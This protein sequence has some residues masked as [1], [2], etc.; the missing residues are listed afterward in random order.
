MKDTM[1][2]KVKVSL[3]LLAVIIFL[4]L[5]LYS[6]KSRE[7]M[8]WLFARTSYYF[9][10]AL[11]LMWL[12]QLGRY[13]SGVDFSPKDFVK[14][15]WPGF[16]LALGVTSIVFATIPVQFK[17]LGDETNLLS[18]SQDM[19]YHKSA[20]IISM[21]TFYNG[22]L[23]VIDVSIPNRPL[24]FPFAINI[25]HS[26]LGYRP[27]NV[28]ILNF[29]LMFIFLAGVYVAIKKAIDTPTAVAGI[30]LILAYPIITI[31]ATSGGYDLFSTLLFAV[32]LTVF[33]RFLKSPDEKSLAFLWVSLLIFSNIRYESCIFFPIIIAA[34]LS[35]I[36]FSYFKETAYIY[37][38][39]PLLSLPFIWQRFLSLG[40]YEN[41]SNIPLF[42]VQSFIKHGKIFLQNYLNLNLDLPYSGFLNLAA[43][44]IIGY[45]F[46][47]IV[48]QK[49]KLTPS[50][51]NLTITLLLCVTVIMVIVLSHHFG[52]YD[53]PTQARLFMY[54]SVFCALAP[55][56]L[57][58]V[59]P[60]W[61]SGK[62]LMVASFA[63][64]LFY[65][66]V[67]GNHAFINN[68]VITRIH[69]YA[70]K[71]LKNLNDPDVL[72]ISAYAGQY[73]ALNY[74]AVTFNYANQHSQS[75]LT[76]LK[77]H[78]YSKILVLQE[79]DYTTNRPKWDNQRLD[80]RFEIKPLEEIQVLS[81]RFLRISRLV[82]Q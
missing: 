66:P 39:S 71:F 20:Y 33:Y 60:D 80:S 27:A 63:V 75:L 48:T 40:T 46:K 62:K 3:A 25:I 15:H 8:V 29:M 17:I 51:K 10:F 64:F 43:V 31:S 11:C 73:T 50:Q 5:L 22:S 6:F 59:Y 41:P 18:V 68:M 4:G 16:V 32:I 28:F 12:I 30:F 44:L 61:I 24:L 42:S 55:V 21:A 81:D 69:Q 35:V 79:I 54:F 70:Q 65:H 1:P 2:K 37:L 53:R 14:S 56:F 23:Q 78:R 38:L 26:V 19:Y 82:M 67:A 34:A 13:L 47:Q 58:A 45:G 57:K 76:E 7:T 74:S 52:R 49:I 9:I 72:I 77:A 36:K